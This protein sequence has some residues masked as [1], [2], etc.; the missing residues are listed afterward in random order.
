M[1]RQRHE[2]SIASGRQ[3]LPANM[4]AVDAIASANGASVLFVHGWA[5]DH[6]HYEDLSQEVADLG[7]V[8]MTFDLRGHGRDCAQ[9]DKV[10]RADNLEDV[11]AAYDALAGWPGVDRSAIAMVAIW[12]PSPLHFGRCDRLP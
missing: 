11:L 4:I 6:Q 2:L 10:S 8:C 12:Q 1:K 9:R 3:C 7:C 5:N